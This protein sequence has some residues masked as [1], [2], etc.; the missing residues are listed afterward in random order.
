[1][2]KEKTFV[3]NDEKHLGQLY[4]LGKVKSGSDEERSYLVNLIA[5][6]IR[7]EYYDYPSRKPLEALKASLHKANI[8]LERFNKKVAFVCAVLCSGRLYLAQTRNNYFASI[9]KAKF[10]SLEKVKPIPADAALFVQPKPRHI[11]AYFTIDNFQKALIGFYLIFIFILSSA[12]YFSKNQERKQQI[13]NYQNTL[14]QAKQKFLQAEAVLMFNQNDRAKTLLQES[15]DILSSLPDSPDKTNLNQ[16]I[17]EQI[18]KSNKLI[19]IS[20]IKIV[21]TEEP[22][23]GITRIKN[24]T[25]AFNSENN[26]IYQI[27]QTAKSISTTSINLGY[28]QKATAF[29]PEDVIVFLTDTPG[30]A[31]YAPNKKLEK[32]QANLPAVL[33][34]DIASYNQY[35]Y[36]LTENQIYKYYRTLAG[37][38]GPSAWLKQ[39][40]EFMN[41][42]S[43][44]IDG[45]V[46]V[47]DN[48]QALKF[49]RGIREDFNL[50]FELNQPIKIFTLA[51][52]DYIYVLEKDKI[53]VFDKTGKL[54]SQYISSKF[55]DLKDIWVDKDKTIYLLNNQEILEFEINF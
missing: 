50:N 36:V 41:P 14:G 7:R 1:M 4:I 23:S 55:N 24:N 49:F 5:S 43:M 35:I 3:Y 10:E 30:L 47:L 28:L 15:Q 8:I 51:D 19:E 37:F 17:K 11:W 33:I 40:T 21:N 26:T 46:F 12:V 42:V 39:K 16:Q 31:I 53:L 48:N 18:N 52:L 38:S 20:N 27:K 44:A 54:M 32:A 45:D 34:K 6:T 2:N 22:I 25:Y 9:N 29:E 13:I